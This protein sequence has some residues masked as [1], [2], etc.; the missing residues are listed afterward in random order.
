MKKEAT[1]NWEPP[2]NAMYWLAVVGKI[3]RMS[4]GDADKRKKVLDYFNKEE[5]PSATK[6]FS[7]SKL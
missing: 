2:W 3:E 4:W 7:R 1:S 5:I 6:F